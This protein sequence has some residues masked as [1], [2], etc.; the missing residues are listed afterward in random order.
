MQVKSLQTALQDEEKALKASGTEDFEAE[1]QLATATSVMR[2]MGPGGDLCVP[3]I[4]CYKDLPQLCA[5][6]VAACENIVGRPGRSAV[7]AA[8]PALSEAECSTNPLVSSQI[9]I[10]TVPL[11]AEG[12]HKSNQGCLGACRRKL[13]KVK[14]PLILTVLLGRHIN[15]LTMQRS[16]GI[17]LKVR[18]THGRGLRYATFSELSDFTCVYWLLTRPRPALSVCSEAR[19]RLDSLHNPTCAI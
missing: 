2:G 17:R 11:T 8:L 15:V 4:L 13:L 18:H 6:A 9:Y 1:E 16:Q 3:S 7:F 10:S 12:F 5:L 19:R 14:N